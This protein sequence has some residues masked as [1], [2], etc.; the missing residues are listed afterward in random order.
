MQNMISKAEQTRSPDQPSS[1]KD[2]GLDEVNQAILL[3]LFH[4]SFSFVPYVR[5]IARRICVPKSIIYRRLVD[6]LHFTVRHQTSDIFIGFLTSSPTV[7]RQ[8]KSSRVVDPTSRP[9]VVHP[10]SRIGW[11]YI[12]PTL[13]LDE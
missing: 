8:I 9:S 3:A 1:P 12:L 6:S 2:D 4:E 7:R 10:A 13:A 5:Q 11:R